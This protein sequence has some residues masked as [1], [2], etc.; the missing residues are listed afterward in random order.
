[1]KFI[2]LVLYAHTK[3]KF[4]L[5]YPNGNP[6]QTSKIDAGSLNLLLSTGEVLRFPLEVEDNLLKLNE[7]EVTWEAAPTD[8]YEVTVSS[9]GVEKVLATGSLLTI[10]D[11]TQDFTFRL[12]L[13]HFPFF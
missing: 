6:I 12:E 3:M 13:E 1:M 10:S 11:E 4:E 7:L 5:V 9:G 2:D 8:N